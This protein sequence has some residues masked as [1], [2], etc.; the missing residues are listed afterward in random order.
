MIRKIRNFLAIRF[1]STFDF[2]LIVAA[3]VVAI[4]S[5]ISGFSQLMAAGG[6]G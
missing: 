3:I 5:I 1:H 4:A 6:G 2:V